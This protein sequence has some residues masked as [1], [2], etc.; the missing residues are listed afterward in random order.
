[1]KIAI[2][3][4]HGGFALKNILKQHLQEAGYEVSDCGTDSEESCDYPDFAEKACRQVQSGGVSLAVLICGT[5]I[6]MSIA[7]NKMKG[8][9][10]ALCHDEFSARFARAHNDANVLALGARVVGPGLAG[11]ILDVF[12][13]GQFEGGRHER[14]LRKIASIEEA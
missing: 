1:M 4:D 9:R 10:A 7:A 11:S 14:R 8:I 2:A 13:T 12:L 3:S 5:G 6:G